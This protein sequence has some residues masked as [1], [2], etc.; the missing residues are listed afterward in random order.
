MSRTCASTP[1]DL[2]AR[3]CGYLKIPAAVLLDRG[4]QATAKIHLA[5][6]SGLLARYGIDLIAEKIENEST[7]VDLFDFD[8]K[9]GQ[10]NL[11]SPPRPIRPE[12][13]ADV[14]SS[15]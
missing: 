4:N 8:V 9:Y 11:F 15:R 6:L 5:D 7:V 2:A 13:M 3:K 14:A 12:S 1:R 10:G